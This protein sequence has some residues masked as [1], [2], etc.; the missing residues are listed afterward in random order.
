[1]IGTSSNFGVSQ[2]TQSS[3]FFSMN[4]GKEIKEKIEICYLKD[5]D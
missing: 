1:M 3:D 5:Y 4:G 2:Y